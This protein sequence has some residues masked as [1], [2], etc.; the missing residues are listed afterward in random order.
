MSEDDRWISPLYQD[1][2]L[3]GTAWKPSDNRFATRGEIHG[4]LQDADFVLVGEK[5]NNADHHRYQSLLIREMFA[6]HRRPAIVFEMLTENQ[7]ALLD[8]HLADNPKDS[9]GIGEAVGWEVRGWPDWRMYRPITDV[10]LAHDAPLLAG[11]LDREATRA[12][13]SQGVEALGAARARRLRLDE[14]IGEEMRTEMRSE[15][16]ESHCSQLP[17]QMLDPMVTVT[18]AKDA[19]MAEAMIGGR[20]LQGR[21]SALLIAGTGHVRA[22]W[23]VPWHLAKLAPDTR[24]VSIGLVEVVADEAE[25]DAYA[26]AFGG[27]LPFDFV[28]F[29]PRVDD[30]NPCEVFAEQLRQMRAKKERSTN[31]EEN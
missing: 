4:A 9:V 14:P 28:W 10:A 7:Q 18:L 19:T 6:Q 5:H 26:A 8:S 30:D 22:D 12:V 20:A 25:P 11:G 16:Y 2:P 27:A 3:A 13:S 29:A 24:I 31:S 15:I 1:H 21:D 23:G 17:E